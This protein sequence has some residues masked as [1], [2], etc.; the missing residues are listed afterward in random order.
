MYI[1]ILYIYIYIYIYVHIYIYT[2]IYVYI[3]HR[4]RFD[5]GLVNFAGVSSFWLADVSRKNEDVFIFAAQ[6]PASSIFAGFCF[7][8]QGLF[9]RLIDVKTALRAGFTLVD[10]FSRSKSIFR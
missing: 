4:G 6:R 10:A 1:Y 8:A 5:T 9:M 7:A 3:Y 2:C